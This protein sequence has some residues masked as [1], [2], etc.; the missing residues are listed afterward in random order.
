[1]TKKENLI[2]NKMQD[3]KNTF[4]L[5]NQN[6]TLNL[7]YEVGSVWTEHTSQSVQLKE[8]SVYKK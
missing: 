5:K 1:M 3:F 7:S 2:Q 4:F 6:S 8:R